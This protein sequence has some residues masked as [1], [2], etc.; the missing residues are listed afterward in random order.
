MTTQDQNPQRPTATWK[1]WII[2]IVGGALVAVWMF[3]T[4]DDP[5]AT[6]SSA[7]Q[8]GVWAFRVLLVGTFFAGGWKA[9]KRKN[10]SS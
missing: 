10:G 9:L 6:S 5:V 7:T 3:T 2:G 8:V 1:L 4:G